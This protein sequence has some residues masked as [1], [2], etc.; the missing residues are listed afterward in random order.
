[1]DSKVFEFRRKLLEYSEKAIKISLETP[2]GGDV[3]TTLV[4]NLVDEFGTIQN[5]NKPFSFKLEKVGNEVMFSYGEN[6]PAKVS[7]VNSKPILLTLGTFKDIL[8]FSGGQ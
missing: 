1:M 3:C 7:E 5:K 2:S 4:R 8:E 6:P